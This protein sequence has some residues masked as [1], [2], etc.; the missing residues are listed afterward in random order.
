M[1]SLRCRTSVMTFAGRDTHLEAIRPV[2][3]S[4]IYVSDFW[5]SHSLLSPLPTCCS[6]HT[7][8]RSS[9]SIR[10]TLHS[11]ISTPY[12]RS[13][14]P[15]CARRRS[16]R[17]VAVVSAVSALPEGTTE[18]DGVYMRRAVE[19]A[20]KALGKTSPNP[21]VGCVIVKDGEVVGEGF[22]PK[23]GEP[24]A[25]VFALRQAGAAAKGATAFVSLEPC[26]HFGRTPPCTQ[27]L[28][29]AGVKRV[30]VGAL[31]QNP[32]VAGEGVKRLRQAG[33]EVVVGVEEE[34]CRRNVEA[35]FFRMTEKRP[36]A[37]MRFT[38]SMDGKVL[39]GTGSSSCCQ[40]GYYS[41]LL[42]EVDAVVVTDVAVLD[43][44]VDLLSGEEGAKQPLRVVAART[45]DLPRNAR[46]FNTSMAKTM[47]VTDEAA[48]VEDVQR[49]SGS[50][51]D[52]AETWLR[53]KGVEVVVVEELSPSTILDL[54]QQ[55]DIV[56]LL[57][58]CQGPEG[59]GLE[60]YLGRW[61]LSEGVVEKVCIAVVPVIVGESGKSGG[62][63]F[64]LDKSN[65]RIQLENIMT[66]MSGDDV[67]I[68]GYLPKST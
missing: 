3:T 20:R 63:G 33:I 6:S 46:V 19:L 66:T 51:G 23:A 9:D 49:A 11:L 43:D 15:A 65:G 53:E 12:S 32:V 41:C 7:L 55:R 52:A 45:L 35:F 4:L 54:C 39:G 21:I 36:M 61:A 18:E 13:P 57:W 37:I 50:G 17:N 40:G 28:I 8:K 25:E 29:R 1:T 10:S 68:T 24:H 47:V 31:D 48:L 59:S 56:S 38:M 30:V 16:K 2:S 14:A 58:D 44:D 60:S 27:A 62:P 67:I 5:G 34:I 22:H 64:L 42:S 26:N